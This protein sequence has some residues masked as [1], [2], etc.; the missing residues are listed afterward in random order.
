M[1]VGIFALF[2]CEGGK[3]LP[4][5]IS[6]SN[7]LQNV[8]LFFIV[9]FVFSFSVFA[10]ENS[11]TVNYR[12]QCIKGVTIYCLAQGIG[13]RKAGNF[14][15][16]L[17]YFRLACESH[18]TMGHLR[19]CTPYLSLAM[20]MGILDSATHKLTNRCEGGEDVTCFYLAKEFLKIAAYERAHVMLER[21]CKERFHPADSEDYG[22]CYHLGVS[23]LTTKNP[24]KARD[25]FGFDCK[26][27]TD[28]SLPSC[29]YYSELVRSSR[30]M[31]SMAWHFAENFLILVVVTPLVQWVLA[32]RGSLATR[33]YV[34]FG[35]PL[36][37]GVGWAMWQF[38][39]EKAGK[40]L[41]F[42]ILPSIFL[43]VCISWLVKVRQG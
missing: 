10:G 24:G 13:E 32:R 36:L 9:I 34:I 3:L 23:Y 18:P 5:H 42:I 26:Q 2:C 41:Y 19:A 11:E 6:F 33:N 15:Q 35:G 40:E 29:K 31:S 8:T 39:T 17:E 28:S 43:A 27:K 30:E 12:D 25:I 14:K 22:P 37:V 20:E 1:K 21:L 38:S 4:V 7:L 16:A